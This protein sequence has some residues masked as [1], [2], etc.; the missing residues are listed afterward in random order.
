M[1][2]S[3]SVSLFVSLQDSARITKPIFIKFGG[4]GA[5]GPRKKPLDFGRN[6]DH[7]TLGLR[8]G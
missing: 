7:F 5:H 1:F 3:A 2:S 4:K 6:P 8:L